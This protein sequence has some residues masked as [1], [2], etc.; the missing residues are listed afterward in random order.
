MNCLNVKGENGKIRLI[1]F[2]REIK[3]LKD[4]SEISRFAA[5]KFIEIGNRSFSENGRFTVALA[6]GSTPKALYQLLTTD[7][8]KNRI[9]WRKVFFFF[10]DERNVPPDS[11]KSN[12]QMANENLLQPLQISPENI[13]RWKTELKNVEKTARQYS[14]TLENFF[15]LRENPPVENN[16][17]KTFPRF[18]LI[19]LG[20]GDDGHTASLFPFIE[21]LDET[22]K[23]AA[24]NRVEK[25][26]SM[27][28][29]LTFPVINN[30]SNVLFL[31][32]GAEKA[33]ALRAVLQGDFQPEK[34]PAQK[35]NPKNGKL[36][37]LI[38][39]PAAHLLQR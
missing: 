24:A 9:D 32:S 15:D 28:L 14:E 35:V 16:S 2:M 22:E 26:D 30:A 19:L 5:R 11:K 17:D 4:L 33:E 34:Y 37:W 13:F 36:F 12:F 6:G 7:E 23:I 27:R 3:I 20:M 31:V 18:D 8:F 38:D 1:S 25:L 10:G 29:T 39:E 21:A